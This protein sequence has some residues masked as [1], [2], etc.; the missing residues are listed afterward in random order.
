MNPILPLTLPQPVDSNLQKYKY[1]THDQLE[2]DWLGS[3]R[4]LHQHFDGSHASS[5]K[6]RYEP[7]TLVWVL[8]SKG[9]QH[10]NFNTEAACT[11]Y[12]LHKK[13]RDKKHTRTKKKLLANG[14]QRSGNEDDIDVVTDN[15]KV[16]NENETI[17]KGPTNLTHGYHS[18]SEMFQRARVVCD[19]DPLEDGVQFEKRML[20]RVMVRYSKGS[21]YR[22]RAFNL[23]PSKCYIV[24]LHSK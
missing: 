13:R 10:S 23:V 14:G 3:A 20:R 7:G 22:V 24:L 16:K 11:S 4:T 9:R 19:D 21:T 17:I 6:A 2:V 8:Q 5:N 15:V 12:M 18:K 1:I